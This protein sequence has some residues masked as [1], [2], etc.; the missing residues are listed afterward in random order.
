MIMHFL[1]FEVAKSKKSVSCE[2][3]VIDDSIRLEAEPANYS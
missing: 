3:S 1:G 2:E